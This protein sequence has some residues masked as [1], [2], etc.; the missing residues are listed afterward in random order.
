[1]LTLLFLIQAQ[2]SNLQNLDLNLSSVKYPF[3][4]HFLKLHVQKI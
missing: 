2:N 4:V 1:L 3:D